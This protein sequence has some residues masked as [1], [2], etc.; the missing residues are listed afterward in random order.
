[1]K[2]ENKRMKLVYIAGPFRG[3][4]F[5]KRSN[6][7][8]ARNLSIKLW[9]AGVPN[10]CPHTNSGFLDSPETD[11]IILPADIEIMKRCDAVVVL[12]DWL[13]STGTRTEL[14]EAYNSDI[15]I[16]FNADLL[17]ADY[18]RDEF[19]NTHKQVVDMINTFMERCIQ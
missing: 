1:M 13:E 8:K 11:K 19:K 12:K 9:E 2:M 5:V 3:S 14:I 4:Y 15:P 10:I 18:H 17:I 6:I 7:K 16:Y